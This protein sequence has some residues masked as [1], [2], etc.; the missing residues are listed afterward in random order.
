MP[1]DRDSEYKILERVAEK[2][3]TDAVGEIR[4]FSEQK[5]CDPSC[6]YVIKKFQEKFPGI[7]IKTTWAFETKDEREWAVFEEIEKYAARNTK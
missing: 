6:Q 4:L 2:L 5:P 7:K 1:R 3:Q